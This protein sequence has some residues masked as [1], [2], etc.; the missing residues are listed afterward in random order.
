MK[1]SFS[2]LAVLGAFALSGAAAAADDTE[3]L[4]ATSAT[5]LSLAP[6]D[7][8]AGLD[9]TEPIQLPRRL[10]RRIDDIN[11]VAKVAA[12][13]AC[14][15]QWYDAVAK[16]AEASLVS[17][18]YRRTGA[19]LGAEGAIGRVVRETN[20]AFDALDACVAVIATTDL[21]CQPFPPT[22]QLGRYLLRHPRVA[23]A[24]IAWYGS[25]RLAAVAS[26]L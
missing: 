14:P 12:C 16:V 4:A 6:P 15:A 17:R 25:Q 19:R 2:V 7:S 8:S 11:A 5:S 1:T 13:Y 26:D 21:S 23:K 20:A 10:Q 24:Y 3:P 22:R 18:E 9:A